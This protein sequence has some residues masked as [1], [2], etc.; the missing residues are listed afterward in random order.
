MC[1]CLILLCQIQLLHV[2]WFWVEG[3]QRLMCIS[4]IAVVVLRSQ[5][6]FF[7]SPYTKQIIDLWWYILH[8]GQYMQA[9]PLLQVLAF[10]DNSLTWIC[11]TFLLHVLRK[12]NALYWKRFI[13]SDRIFLL[14]WYL[15]NNKVT[16]VYWS[17]FTLSEQNETLY[18]FL[19]SLNFLQQD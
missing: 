14:S 2:K 19:I 10:C 6:D 3:S 15:Q 17:K 11:Q 1:L 13:S 8:L 4:N 12:W 16:K 9:S 5:E 18:F 7:F